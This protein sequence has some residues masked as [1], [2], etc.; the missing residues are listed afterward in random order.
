[1]P[2][3]KLSIQSKGEGLQVRTVCLE[4]EVP[5]VV[6][7]RNGRWANSKQKKERS[8]AEYL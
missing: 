1:M 8:Q 6:F 4:Q 7:I 2:S 3:M 5:R